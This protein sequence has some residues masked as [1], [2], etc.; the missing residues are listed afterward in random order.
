MAYISRVFAKRL[1]HPTLLFGEN[2]SVRET[3][4]RQAKVNHAQEAA[5]RALL[6]ALM[7]EEQEEA[8]LSQINE[9]CQEIMR[10]VG[11]CIPVT[12][13]T[14]FGDR[15]NEIANKVHRVWRDIC[16]HEYFFEAR[17]DEDHIWL[18][19]WYELVFVDGKPEI[20]PQFT[21]A[22]NPQDKAILVI[23]PRLYWIDERGDGPEQTGVVLMESQIK[24]AKEEFGKC[25]AN[26]I[27]QRRDSARALPTRSRKPSIASTT[28]TGR[29]NFLESTGSDSSK[30]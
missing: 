15:L 17:F 11:A 7:P 5:F 3:L 25:Q 21:E 29:Q 16:H 23:Y 27:L 6:L 26:E 4:A 30:S 28:S 19:P 8:A 13:G 24:D 20:R 2:R 22:D 9:A 12:N 10:S 1:F 18:H 14:K